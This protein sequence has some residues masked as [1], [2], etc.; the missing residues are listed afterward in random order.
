MHVGSYI[1]NLN[2]TNL[3]QNSNS[4]LKRWKEF[5]KG[6]YLNES[7]CVLDAGNIIL[8]MFVNGLGN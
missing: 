7:M 4:I 3:I 5:I 2:N 1:P 6:I 8:K